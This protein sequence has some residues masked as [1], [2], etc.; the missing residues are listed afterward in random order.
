MK[1]RRLVME[2]RN[3]NRRIKIL[4]FVITISLIISFSPLMIVSFPSQAKAGSFTEDFTTTARKDNA[5]TTADWNTALG[6]LRLPQSATGNWT[7]A[8]GVTNGFDNVSNN[9]GT[10][11]YYQRIVQMALGTDGKPH[12][13]WQDDTNGN[14][15]ICYSRWNGTQWT[16]ADGTTSPNY[17]NVSNSPGT[18]NMPNFILDS[19]SKPHIVWSEIVTS[20]AAPGF[21]SGIPGVGGII[22]TK[23]YDIMYSRWNGS[24]WTKADGNIGTDNLS[25]DPPSSVFPLIKLDANQKPHV[26]WT[27]IGGGSDINYIRWN[28]YAWT[29]ADDS[30]GYDT[31]SPTANSFNADFLID[32]SNNAQVT[33]SD[34]TTGTGG[35]LYAHWN[36]SAWTK[37]NGTTGTDNVSN[38]SGK[39]DMPKI[40]L[41]SYSRPNIVWRDSTTGTY[42][43]YF[44]KW[45]GTTW[46]GLATANYDNL[47]NNVGTSSEPLLAMDANSKPHIAWYDDTNTTTL[48]IANAAGNSYI[49]YTRWNGSNW[50]KADGANLGYDIIGNSSGENLF[51]DFVLDAN[52]GA[53]L[54]WCNNVTAEIHYTRWNGT[55]WTKADGTTPGYDNASNSSGLSAYPIIRLDANQ[56]P[57]IA[58]QEYIGVAIGVPTKSQSPLPGYEVVIGAP[59]DICYS[60]YGG[61]NFQSPRQAQSTKINTTTESIVKA[62]LNEVITSTSGGTVNYYLSANGGTNWESVTPGVEH[63][64]TNSGNDLRWK[65]NLSTTDPAVTPEVDSL[66]INYSSQ[67]TPPDTQKPSGTIVINDGAEVTHTPSVNLKLQAHDNVGVSQMMIS[68][69]SNFQGGIWEG[70]RTQKAWTL[71]SGDGIKTVYTKFKDTSDLVSDVASDSIRLQAQK[72]LI[73]LEGDTRYE[74]AVAISKEGFPHGAEYV[75]L[76]RGDLFPDALAGAPLCAKLN[77]PLL[78]T[79]SSSLSPATAAEIK[80]LAAKKAIILG[81]EDAVSAQVEQDLENLCSITKSNIKRIGGETRYETA[82]DIAKELKPLSQKICF[83]A[84]GEN[85]P[86]ALASSSV[87]AFKQIPIM[88]VRGDIGLVPTSTKEAISDLGIKEAIITGQEDVVPKSIEGYLISQNISTSRFGGD[89]RYDTCKLI[90][91]D[92]LKTKG[93][94]PEVI[95]LAV[96][97]NFPDALTLGPFAAKKNSIILLTR[98][99]FIPDSIKKFI[100]DRK[101]SIYSVYIAGSSDVVSTS[102]EEEIKNIVGI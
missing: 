88:L 97:E 16:K 48:T 27:E 54:V 11:G 12:L 102:V 22:I 26:V 9:E 67:T 39:S 75:I 7:K 89:T 23:E 95:C 68:N 14:M 21:S 82:R 84:T 73:R 15:E 79:N 62:T 8:D 49:Y 13:V 41:D 3:K 4:S 28:G 87:A 66:S 31:L 1:N 51:H 6:K 86:D 50:T 57:R 64:F 85:Y 43:I 61:I 65:A 77:S 2:K 19:S 93:L 10:S 55:A 63:T 45:N 78:L 59:D 25:N 35:I 47:S 100:T 56:R 99:E 17:D 92:A 20:T 60:Q 58:W 32:S 72:R 18:S 74:T 94:S 70:Y 5:N 34:Y 46:T 98:T 53:H 24:A 90:A 44:S 96:G 37:A 33:W 81:T 38:T 71:T 29:K 69:Y 83:V 80:R 52:S 36:G 40:K 91:D 101:D 76:A 42:D 30:A